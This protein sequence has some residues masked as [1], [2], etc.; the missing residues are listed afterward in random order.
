VEEE[1]VNVVVMDN[2]S[3]LNLKKYYSNYLFD[4]DIEE[5]DA[6]VMVDKFVESS[7]LMVSL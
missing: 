5:V 6:A 1:E 7:I 4:Y 3:N 2:C